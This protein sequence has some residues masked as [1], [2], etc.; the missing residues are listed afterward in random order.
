MKP[1][2]PP[3]LPALAAPSAAGTSARYS[4]VGVGD[5][6]ATRRLYL[7]SLVAVAA[8]GGYF[9]LTADVED[10]LHRLL[11]LTIYTLALWPA[12]AWIKAG[13]SRFPV[14]EPMMALCANAYAIPLLSGHTILRQFPTEHITQAAIAVILYQIAAILTYR[15]VGGRPA[16]GRFWNESVLNKTFEQFVVYGLVASTAYTGVSSFTNLI[17]GEIESILRAVFSGITVLATFI[18]SQRWGRGEL[19]SSQKTTFAIMIVLQVIFQAT[20]LMLIG[21]ITL[22]GIAALGFMSAGRNLPVFTLLS[23]FA[24]IAV[25]HNG[26]SA[27]REV[28]W[29][30]GI[31]TRPAFTDLPGFF[32]SWFTA[33]LSPAA[34][35]EDELQ[36]SASARLLDRASLMQMLTLVVTNTPD[37]QPFLNGETYQYVLPQ[38]IPRIV[39]PDKPPSHVGTNRLSVYYG[40]QDEESTVSTTIAFGMPAEAY[41]NFGLLGMLGLGALFGGGLKKLQV[42]ST[43]SPMFSLAGIL[44]ILLTAWSLNAEFTMAVW[45][46]SLFQALVVALGTPIIVRSLIGD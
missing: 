9:G 30:G 1:N 10:P 2:P 20:G 23:A 32:V 16:K 28:Y 25:L 4:L 18:T 45:V 40:L 33:G 27:M 15:L 29:E 11:G 21:A 46:S 42:L 7:L 39:W 13:G 37:R 38:L 31:R 5:E 41:A 12:L 44:M 36:M 24:V 34:E 6:R 8:G 35:T 17:P 19:N 26:K 14:F 3:S 22:I 43:N